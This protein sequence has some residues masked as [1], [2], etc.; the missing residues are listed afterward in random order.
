MVN[1]QSDEHKLDAR[2]VQRKLVA[3]Q[4]EQPQGQAVPLARIHL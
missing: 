3:L 4:A 1:K 2:H